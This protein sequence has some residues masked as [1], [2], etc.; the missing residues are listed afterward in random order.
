MNYRTALASIPPPG[1]GCHP[2]LLKVAGLGIRE[3]VDP[4]T[5]RT[6]IRRAIPRG[7]RPVADHEI[8]QAVRKASDNRN[9]R[10]PDPIQRSL[11]RPAPLRSSTLWSVFLS[12]PHDPSDL[13]E[14]SPVRLTDDPIADGVLLLE[15]LYQPG[16]H[17]FIGEQTER[18]VLTVDRWIKALKTRRYW[19]HIMPNPLTGQS[20]KTQTG[21]MSPRC[22]AAV[23]AF[24]YAVVEFDEI[25]VDRQRRF[26]SNIIDRQLLDVAAV[27]DSGGKS[28]HGWVRVDCPDR[29]TWDR[30]VRDRL[31]RQF[32]VPI[33][34]DR[35]CANPSRL[36]R[37][38]GHQRR[39]DRLQQLLYLASGGS[40]R[41]SG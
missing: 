16:E 19:P 6:D 30:E 3:G 11:W 41:D 36:S 27:I 24:R 21:K 29:G 8:D 10:P 31:F 5:I 4:G 38:P 20:A 22:D 23:A 2:F 9:P 13:W 14:R 25:S 17:L 12:E 40:L 33:G 1:R 18:M 32:L 15:T 39:P 34:A 37:L 35:A 26:W 7:S 28:L